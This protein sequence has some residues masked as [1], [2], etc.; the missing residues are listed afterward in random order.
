MKGRA[1]SVTLGTDIQTGN[2][3]TLGDTERCSGLYVLGKPGMGKSTLLTNMLDYDMVHGNSVFFLDPHGEA[4]S[5][6]LHG[7]KAIP[8]ALEY[9]NIL[10]LDPTDEDY[11]FGIN[12]LSC[13]NVAS[14]KERHTTYTRTHNVFQKLFE[15]ERGDLGV[16]L[17]LIIQH[18]LPVFI[19]NQGYTL[20]E[21][22]LFL[23]DEDFRKH[24]LQ[25]VRYETEV[26]DF[27]EREFQPK[28]AE[29]A[30]TRMRRFL[31]N[32]YIRHIVGQKDT[33][34]D[35]T[36][37]VIKPPQFVFVRLPAE[38]SADIK[39]FIGTILLSEL[40]HAIRTRPVEA[41]KRLYGVY[42]DEFQH[43]ATYEDMA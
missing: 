35:F 8:V 28:Q 25:N 3:I 11:S 10:L 43:F 6:L 26:L 40:L 38:L 21:I 42:V 24:L 18:T 33:T 14:L 29:S 41:R 17:Q 37:Y 20:A 39:K 23:T 9:E 7:C 12:L 16:W 5:D 13:P 4:I 30:I 1:M 15:N 19:E 27:W 2:T 36:K 22:P 31:G 32:A 34:I